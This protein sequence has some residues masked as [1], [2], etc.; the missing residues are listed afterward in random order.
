[1][2]ARL[3]RCRGAAQMLSGADERCHGRAQF[4]VHAAND[5]GL[6]SGGSGGGLTFAQRSRFGLRLRDVRRDEAAPQ[7][8]AEA[9]Q[10]KAANERHEIERI[11]EAVQRVFQQRQTKQH[12]DCG[13]CSCNRER[14]RH[15]QRCS[16]VGEAAAEIDDGQGFARH[17]G[18]KPKQ[19]GENVA[20][21]ALKRGPSDEPAE[22][23]GRAS[24]AAFSEKVLIDQPIHHNDAG[25]TRE[26]EQRERVSDNRGRHHRN[27]RAGA[28]TQPGIRDPSAAHANE[29]ARALGVVMRVV[30]IRRRVQRQGGVAQSGVIVTKQPCRFVKTGTGFA[31][32]KSILDVTRRGALVG[33][34]GRKYAASYGFSLCA[35]ADVCGCRPR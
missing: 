34:E 23:F 2:G 17:V 6:R 18:R 28:D 25:E 16:S 13:P 21:E 26:P 20:V 4:V 27:D 33:V 7:I 35:D 11:A 31:I 15:A 22:L 8:D 14:L 10:Q 29:R 32:G 30:G 12:G 3:W 9:E 19:R 24:G 1:M 5:V